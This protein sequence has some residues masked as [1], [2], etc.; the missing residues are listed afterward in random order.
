[1]LGVIEKE[2]VCHGPGGEIKVRCL[3]IERLVVGLMLNEAGVVGGCMPGFLRYSV[4]I[5]FSLI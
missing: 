1:M 4:P 3:V 5:F 2:I